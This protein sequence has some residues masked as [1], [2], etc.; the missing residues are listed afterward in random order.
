MENKNAKRI[1]DACKEANDIS[2]D[3]Q[4]QQQSI[5][6]DFEKIDNILYTNDLRE[7]A[8]VI[9]LIACKYPDIAAFINS[10]QKQILA[11]MIKTNTSSI[12]LHQQSLL[13]LKEALQNMMAC[14]RMH[15]IVVGRVKLEVKQA[16]E[17]IIN[18]E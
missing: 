4:K 5:K 1:Y 11:M 15:R 14:Y 3:I 12:T 16:I 17:A 18:K 7:M 9:T 13:M 10:D 6:N 2:Q 8:N